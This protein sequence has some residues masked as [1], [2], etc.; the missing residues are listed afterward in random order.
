MSD[1]GWANDNLGFEWLQ[2]MFEKHTA[3]QTAGRYRLLILD[4]HST[5]QLPSLIISAW[6]GGLSPY[7]CLL[8]Y[9]ITPAAGYKL[10]C[11]AQALLW[12]E[13]QGDGTERYSCH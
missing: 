11:A 9:L 2:D 7:I 3:S 1:N 5:M 13:N 4:G 10:F 12:P 6:K 8:I